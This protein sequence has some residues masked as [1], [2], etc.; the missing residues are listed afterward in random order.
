MKVSFVVPV[1]LLGMASLG[2]SESSAQAELSDIYAI[3][4]LD[5][6]TTVGFDAR[7]ILV[8]TTDGFRFTHESVT[9]F[10]IY[11]LSFMSSMFGTA[12]GDAGTILRSTNRGATWASQSSGTTNPLLA[13]SFVD[14]N[15]GSTVGY[16]GTIL[17]T[18]DGGATWIAQDSGVFVH[19]FGVSFIDASNGMAVGDIG[20]ILHTTNGGAT[21][22][23]QA[24]GTTR[25]LQTVS[26]LDTTRAIAV[27]DFGTILRTTDAGE[28]WE[29]QFSGTTSHLF[30]LSSAD[31]NSLVA[32]G[33]ATTLDEDCQHLGTILRSSDGGATW[34]DLSTGQRNILYSVSFFG[35]DTGT[36]AGENNFILRTVDGGIT[37]M[38][39]FWRVDADGAR[40]RAGVI[41][42]SDGALYGT[43][44][45]GGADSRGTVFRVLPNGTNFSVFYSFPGG[46][47]G[48]IPYELLQG[49]DGR[50][51]GTASF[52]TDTVSGT[53]VFRM[54]PDGSNFSVLHNFPRVAEITG[55]IQASDGTLYGTTADY[56]SNLAT[57]FGML[58]DGSAFTTLRSFPRAEGPTD[59]LMQA[60]DGMLYW[61]AP[62]GDSLFQGVV[63]RL[64]TDGSDFTALHIFN[65]PDGADP[66]GK[67]V[68]AT[69]GTLYGTTRAGGANGRGTVFGIRRDGSGFAVLHSFSFTPPYDARPL[70]GVIQATDGKLYGTTSTPFGGTVFGV[71]TDGTGFTVLHR[72]DD[73]VD[74]VDPR[75][76][77]VEASDGTLWGTTNDR[78]GVP[79]GKGTVFKLRRDGGGFTTI[80]T[81]HGIGLE[82][83]IN[84]SADLIQGTNGAFYGTASSGGFDESGSPLGR[85]T[86][87][88]L[89][90]D[91]SYTVLH[92]FHFV[93]GKTPLA[94]LI[95][96][97]NGALYGTTYEGPGNPGVPRGTVFRINADGTGF[98]VLHTF[99]SDFSDGAGPRAPLIEASDGRL[100]GTA[101][102]YGAGS[103]GTIFRMLPDGTGYQ[104]LR[105]FAGHPSDG[106]NPRAL[107]QG[108]D[109]ALYGIT[110]DGGASDF[111]SVFRM[112]L[113]GSGFA[114]LHSFVGTDGANPEGGLIQASDDALYGTT[115]L[116]GGG[117]AGTIFKLRP[118][119]SGFSV[120]HSFTGRDGTSPVSGVNEINGILY[121]TT[122][123]TTFRM[124]TDGSDFTLLHTFE[125]GRL[126]GDSSY[127]R[128]LL[129]R[130]GTF[131]G[132]TVLGGG[133]NA[134]TVF[135]IFPDGSGF[136]VLHSFSTS[137]E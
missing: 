23:L 3:A 30:G 120:L 21:W 58:P 47:D 40:P 39:T 52:S 123:D 59:G 136:A 20:T 45:A 25:H 6:N 34:A 26:L 73:L 56:N 71:N 83:G 43:T 66:R 33:C 106:A 95:Q 112:L 76:R 117:F 22:S 94:G 29:P 103:N 111:G 15:T 9:T 1:V 5:E 17:R 135:Q 78:G 77:L 91:G 131:R 126:D 96:A 87:F 81:F 54:L 127:S 35:A 82:G 133:S 27:G 70:F 108:R 99:L 37:W 115:S 44:S 101:A 86:V 16:S 4:A 102:L 19:L 18:T 41:Q 97:S 119:G 104:T 10:P 65:G 137:T 93:E 7:G 31:S 85:G 130:D 68:E 88:Q 118:D 60:S 42:A 24:S 80:H 69:D 32:V 49:S 134:G 2:S 61:L 121:G 124:N 62:G 11:G 105:G 84:P 38:P 50:L 55:L 122:I 100:Y 79:V 116:G 48:G 46:E 125:G 53:L 36:A 110:R 67:L 64:S 92:M 75:G 63:F 14:A 98:A 51:Y 128:L 113:D 57:A 13:V 132:T 12:V 114:L 74:G 72:F 28:T 90:W 107:I 89:S 109:G 8:R 129:A